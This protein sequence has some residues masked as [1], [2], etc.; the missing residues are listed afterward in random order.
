MSDDVSSQNDKILCLSREH[1]AILLMILGPACYSCGFIYSNE[2][3]LHP[4]TTALF[5][6][7][8]VVCVT[9]LIG[10]QQGMDLTFKNSHN[11]KW[12][13]IRNSIMILQGLAYAWSQF[14]LPLPV[15]VT[16]QSTSPIFASLFDKLL[17]NIDL[18]FRQ[19][20]WLAVAFVGVI[21]TS[22]GVYISYL[23][24]GTTA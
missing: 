2:H 11:Y 15:A 16:L 24:T 3:K 5:R 8:T 13:T 12:L 23:L 14:Y 10:R 18:N 20:I 17:N 4:L 6:G 1:M 7:V 22:N 9:Y 21:L 19:R